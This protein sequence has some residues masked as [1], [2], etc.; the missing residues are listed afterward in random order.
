MKNSRQPIAVKAGKD[1][2]A[3]LLNSGARQLESVEDLLTRARV[4]LAEVKRTG[5]REGLPELLADVTKLK[6]EVEQLE[7]RPEVACARSCQVKA[8]SFGAH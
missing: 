1:Q 7:E 4:D 5:A 6:S 2:A 8:V 3:S